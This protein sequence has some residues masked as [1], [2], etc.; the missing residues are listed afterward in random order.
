MSFSQVSDDSK[1]TIL[2]KLICSFMPT[3]LIKIRKLDRF[4]KMKF[5]LRDQ[6]SLL[7][8]GSPELSPM[9]TLKSFNYDLKLKKNL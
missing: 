2:R 4:K 3:S 6:S 8:S 1:S 5:A 7:R 9:S